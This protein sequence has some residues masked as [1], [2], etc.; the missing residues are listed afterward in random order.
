M[1]ETYRLWATNVRA[2]RTALG[3]KQYEL[4]EKIG[5]APATVCRWEHE[6]PHKYSPPS[7]LNKVKIAAALHQ[8]VRS[9]FPLLRV[10][11]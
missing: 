2:G 11:A 9:L 10:A 3:L 7:D 8:D 4:A 5:V 6:E 1:Q